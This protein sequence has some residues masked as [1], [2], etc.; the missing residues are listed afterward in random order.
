MQS[1]IKWGLRISIISYTLLHFVTTFLEVEPLLSILA[2]LGFLI[3]LFAGLSKTLRQFKLP[4]FLFA[5][6]LII[7]FFAEGSVW[8]GLYGGFLQMRSIV[9]LLVIV[10]MISWVLREEPYIED[11][12]GMAH[13][14]LNT[15]RKFYLGMMSLTQ[16]FSYFLL[17]GAIPMMYQFINQILKKK[18]NEA[19]ENFKGTA[20]L[21]AFALSTMWVISIP[22]FI[23]AVETM[24]ASLWICILQGFLIAIC[25]I[26]IAVLFSYFQEKH[27]GVNLTY[28][29]Q[30]E[31]DEVLRHADPLEER[32]RKVIEFVVLFLSLFGSIFIIHGLFSADLMIVIPLTILVWT[33]LYY[34]VKNKPRKFAK[35]A[36][37]YFQTSLANQSYQLSIMLAAGVLIFALNQT[38][39]AT[40]VVD[41]VYALQELLPFINFLY[42]LPFIVILLGFLGMGPLTVM[43]LVAGILENIAL[44]YP[45]ELIVLA[46]TSGS[47]ISILISPLIMPV[48]ML[49]ASNG[50]NGFKNGI[51]FNIKYAI[52]FYIMVQIYVQT[53][54]HL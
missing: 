19:W 41:G 22:S 30:Q 44:P 35:E 27:Y 43:V 14:F 6:G 50:L 23:F 1:V 26:M 8:K 16:I 32:K 17:F 45:P 12:M 54:I 25:G 49:S 33:C 53:M 2:V 5:A 52:V 9:G 28:E 39:F 31:I 51:R 48:I 7:L 3:L 11:I 13:R 29:L 15:S 18:R 36:K 40:K 34:A 10:P 21:R 37:I 42:L 46:V 24:N 20:L 4:L 38:N 47:V